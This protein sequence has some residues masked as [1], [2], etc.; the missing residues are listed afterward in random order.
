LLSQELSITLEGGRQPPDRIFLR[1]LAVVAIRYHADAMN[2]LVA[3]MMIPALVCGPC[4]CS[5]S[6]PREKR[7]DKTDKKPQAKLVGRIASISADKKFV[8]IQSYGAWEVAAG[9]ILT[10]QGPDQ[11]VANLRCSGE[12]LGQYAAADIQ[13]GLPQTGDAVFF[14][15]AEP[16]TPGATAP[17]KAPEGFTPSFNSGT[18][19]PSPSPQVP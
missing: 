17:P 15:P 11:R 5:S 10:T 3:L 1:P 7:H 9:S 12:K 6:A 14:R 19:S 4:S 2:R 18:G 13:A 8:T 16:S